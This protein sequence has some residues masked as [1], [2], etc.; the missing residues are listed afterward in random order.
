MGPGKVNGLIAQFLERIGLTSNGAPVTSANLAMV[1]VTRAVAQA[2]LDDTSTDISWTAETRDDLGISAV[3][4]GANVKVCTFDAAGVWA[5]V[6]M[7]RFAADADGYRSVNVVRYN[8]ADVSQNSVGVASFP[9]APATSTFD[10]SVPILAQ[11]A[12]GDYLKVVV[13]HTAGA[14]IDVGGG[15]G[16][17]AIYRVGT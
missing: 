13:R 10:I 8:S 7:L 4:A 17:V 1:R 11:V 3:G 14:T 2:V 12:A 15:Y 6:C 9:S 5:G 16:E